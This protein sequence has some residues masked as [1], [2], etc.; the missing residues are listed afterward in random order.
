MVTGVL[1]LVVVGL[2]WA[3]YQLLMQNGRLSLRLEKIERSLQERGEL[4]DSPEEA[5][6]DGLP[7]GT[8]VHDFELPTLSG[9]A[10]ISRLPSALISSGVSVSIFKRSR[11]GGSMTRARLLPCLVSFFSMPPSFVLPM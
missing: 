2:C 3:V 1:A 5:G 9:G 8:V 6:L 4:A 7:A 10:T 11:I